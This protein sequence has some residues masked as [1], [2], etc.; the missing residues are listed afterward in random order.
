MPLSIAPAGA[1]TLALVALLLAALASSAGATQFTGAADDPANMALPGGQDVVHVEAGYED[2]VGALVLQV[3]FREA[4]IDADVLVAAIGK[5]DSAGQCNFPAGI[6]GGATGGS[7]TWAAWTRFDAGGAQVDE[8]RDGTRAQNGAAV[9]YVVAKPGFAAQGLDCVES[10]RIATPGG[11][12]VET[13]PGFVL[14]ASAAPPPPEAPPATP[15]P[16]A[17]SVPAPAPPGNAPTAT[18]RSRSRS[19]R[20]PAK[21]A[22][23]SARVS[24]AATRTV[25]RGRWTTLKVRVANAGSA[26]ARAAKLTVRPGRGLSVKVAGARRRHPGERSLKTLKPGAASTVTV[27]VRATRAG[28]VT[29]VASGAGRLSARATVTLKLAG[30]ARSGKPR[31]R[32]RRPAGRA[33]RPAA[34]ARRP[35]ARAP[36]L[37]PLADRYFWGFKNSATYAWDNYAVWFVDGRWA[38]YGFP[39]SG[40]PTC[41]APTTVLDD[42]GR[43]TDDGCRPYTYDPA[44]GALTVGDL[45]GTYRDG[46]LT[47]NQISM[48]SLTIPRAGSR[49]AVELLNRGFSGLCGLITGC[50]TWVDYL[51]LTADGHFVDGHSSASTLGDGS[52][53]PFVYAGNYPPNQTGTYEVLANGQIRFSYLDG[54]VKVKSIGVVHDRNGVDDPVNE[55]LVVGET[56]F[57]REDDD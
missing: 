16:P 5:R 35:T 45:S 37:G 14:S 10:V 1:R 53:T 18:P 23:L 51:T 6:V 49:Y 52:S 32:A 56:N 17:P 54:T 19:T 41:T 3:T 9:T 46:S 13:V 44:T 57:Y 22:V 55:G 34:R 2:A 7:V 28:T 21:R 33:R 4:P 26:R 40:R 25:A 11:S 24:G 42:K 48:E 50:T 20:A 30:A 31:A 15:A 8:G 27:R 36:D 12:T 47:L 38:Y 43:P 29:F 39:P